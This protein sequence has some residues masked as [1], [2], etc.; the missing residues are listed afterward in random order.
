MRKLA[1]FLLLIGTSISVW[2]QRQITGKVID[3]TTDAPI[4]GA[5]ITLKGTLTATQSDKGGAFTISVPNDNAVLIISYVEME[6]QEMR[7]GN[8]T[9]LRVGLG[10]RKGSLDEVIVTGYSK[11]RK[12]DLTGSVAVVRCGRYA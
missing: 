4:S 11:E 9:D 12:K 8:Q 3:Q 6:T 10:V 2:S 5:T 1:I 7:V